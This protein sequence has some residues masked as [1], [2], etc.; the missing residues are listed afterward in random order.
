MICS[1]GAEK[2]VPIPWEDGSINNRM[3][4]TLIYTPMAS[5]SVYPTLKAQDK[6]M[7]V[8]PPLNLSYVAAVAKKAGHEVTIIDA[9][10][11]RFTQEDVRRRIQ[12]TK[13]DLIGFTLATD[14]FHQTLV[15]IN[16]LKK[17][18]NVPTLVGGLHVGYYPEETMSHPG[19]D[20]AL[21][22][23]AE[24]NL[25]GFLHAFQNGLGFEGIKGVCYR[26]KKKVVVRNN[27]AHLETIDNS[28]MPARELLDNGLYYSF[29]SQRRN[30]TAMITTRGCPYRCL[31]CSVRGKLRLRSAAN[32]LEEME[33]CNREYGIREI[34]IYD[35]TF[36]VDRK[37]T[38]EICDGIL[39]RN[40]DIV[41]GVRTRIDL[42]EEDLL[43]AMGRA[44]CWVAMYGIESADPDILKTLKKGIE[45][46]RIKEIVKATKRAGISPFGFFIIGSPGETEETIKK[47]IRFAK[48][49][50]LDYVQFSKLSP[51]PAT[52]YYEMYVQKYG[53]DSWREY[54]LD[55]RKLPSFAPLGTDLSTE[56]ITEW[57]RKAYIRFYF[58]PGFVVKMLF[59]I[60]GYEQFRKGIRAA[61]DMAWSR[62]HKEK[63]H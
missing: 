56:E 8:I 15:W 53:T 13:P 20:Y 43:K 9:A 45:L 5:L 4:L 6:N 38:L 52:E 19:I 33:V 44:G 14:S 27:N 10:A 23:E 49:L 41:W 48:E 51:F 2:S 57:V 3:K 7:G 39:K 46:T 62:Q 37:R 32:V 61:L 1:F 54:V 31:F 11:N 30:F 34:D 40:L 59:R 47:T 58:R 21:I 36:S 35:S 22:G 18:T 50:D 28:P 63:M 29:I 60:K 12:E 24:V 26:D 55:A 17:T 16:D 42:V 25:P